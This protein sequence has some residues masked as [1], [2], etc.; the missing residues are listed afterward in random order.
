MNCEGFCQDDFNGKHLCHG[1]CV[2]L[3]QSCDGTCPRANDKLDCAGF[4]S[5]TPLHKLCDDDCIPYKVPCSSKC[6]P[7]SEVL[8]SGECQSSDLQCNGECMSG[9]KK[10]ANCDGTCSYSESGTWICDSECLR[11]EQP[12]HGECPPGMC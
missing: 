7:F 4:C 10:V 12:C 11:K 2:S 3:D 6:H 9:Y 8:C 5:V 1:Q